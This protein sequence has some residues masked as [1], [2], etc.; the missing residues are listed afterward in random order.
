ML[1]QIGVGEEPVDNPEIVESPWLQVD[2][3][4]REPTLQQRAVAIGQ[5]LASND[6]LFFFIGLVLERVR[7]L[8]RE[9][10]PCAPSTNHR[11][12]FIYR[13]T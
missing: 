1:G 6:R 8:E 3:A 4:Y 11:V 5:M 7:A 10:G 13:L 9:T 2:H 12:E